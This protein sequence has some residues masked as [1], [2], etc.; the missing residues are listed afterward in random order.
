[1]VNIHHEWSRV[2]KVDHPSL[3]F[4]IFLVGTTTKYFS[5]VCSFRILLLRMQKYD[6]LSALMPPF[7]AGKMAQYFS[8]FPRTSHHPHVLDKCQGER[9]QGNEKDTEPVRKLLLH[10]SPSASVCFIKRTFCEGEQQKPVW[11]IWSLRHLSRALLS[12]AFRPH[13]DLTS[14]VRTQILEMTQM[15]RE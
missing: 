2:M 4:L 9:E 11:Q 6:F 5:S 1:M 14:I 13:H 12:I 7:F 10:F 3:T 8:D 15:S